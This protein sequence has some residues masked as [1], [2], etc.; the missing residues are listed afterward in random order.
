MN[1]QFKIAIPM[2][3]LG[4]R[5]RPHTWSKPKPLIHV[6]EKTVLDYV[7][8]QFSSVPDRK[9]AEY[10]LIIGPNQREQIEPYIHEKHPEKKVHFV[11]QE[12]MR[13]QSD[14]LY[15]ARE[16]L[17]GAVLMAFS[18]TL[19]ETDLS[20][21]ADEKMD[22][23]AWVKPIPDPRRFGVAEVNE[24]GRVARLIEKP[25]DRKNNLAVVGFYYFK[26]GRELVSAIQEQ[27]KR[28]ISLKGEY[29]LVDAIN[30]MI[31]KGAAFKTNSVEVWLDA[32][33][34]D[35][36]LETNKYLLDHGSANSEQALSRKGITIVPP[37]YIHPSATISSCVIGPYASISSACEISN[38]II[39]N[40]IVEEGA[41]IK[42]MILENSLIGRNASIEGRAEQM[43]IGDDS[44]IEI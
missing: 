3:G 37:V 11:V 32:G 18:D 38:S 15:L 13:G 31:E 19:I 17:H 12:Q 28:D 39:R 20:F 5:M 29:F 43:N 40:S 2:A 33:K 4:T 22:G 27:F 14:A 25:R 24:T 26:E 16:Y 7:L 36:L 21:L 9:N 34:P 6:A 23:I 41:V 10:V 42:E 30:I 44:W 8:D 35:A 1:K